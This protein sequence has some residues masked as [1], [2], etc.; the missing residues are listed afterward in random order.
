MLLFNRRGFLALA[1]FASLSACGFQPV[2]KKGSAATNL[3]GRIEIDLVKGRNG[4]ELRERLEDRLGFA[5]ADAPYVL[6]FKLT[7]TESGIAVTKDKGTTRTNLK[8]VADFTI[9][10]KDTQQIVYKDSVR[11]V[12]AFGLTSATYPSSVAER[13]ANIRMAKALADQIA[14]RI[15]I[16]ANGWAT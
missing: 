5:D 3:Q 13:D 10:R 9:R 14:T 11:N 15:A 16:T 1:G 12:T 4:F 7:L 8:G 2:Y 6:T